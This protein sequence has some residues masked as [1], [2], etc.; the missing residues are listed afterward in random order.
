[1]RESETE[2][3]EKSCYCVTE[4]LHHVIYFYHHSYFHNYFWE[5][6]LATYFCG[7]PKNHTMRRF[8]TLR[9]RQ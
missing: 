1:M 6:L 5:G 9:Q 4:S 8:V 7:M 2:G 3:S